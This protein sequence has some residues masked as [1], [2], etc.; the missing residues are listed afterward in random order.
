VPS[1]QPVGQ[2][3]GVHT[4]DPPWHSVP[5]GQ[6]MQA[7]PFEPQAALV[8]PPWQTLFWQQPDGQLVA[9]QTQEPL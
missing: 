6:A 1:Q 8:F 5:A 9:V 3:A 2:L 4:H 7:T